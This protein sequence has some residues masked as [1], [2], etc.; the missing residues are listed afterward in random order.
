[1]RGGV[2]VSGGLVVIQRGLEGVIFRIRY[3]IVVSFISRG[4][5]LFT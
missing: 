1:M 3:G 2:T 5:Y 4:V